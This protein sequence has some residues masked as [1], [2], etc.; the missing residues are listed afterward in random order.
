MRLKE[1]NNC[2]DSKYDLP[3]SKIVRGK[4]VFDAIFK[5]G[6]S[7]HGKVLSLRYIHSESTQPIYQM[8]FITKKKLGKAV[9][10]NLLRRK[11]RASFRLHQHLLEPIL[12]KNQTVQ[13]LCFIKTANATYQEIYDEMPHLL[14]QMQNKILIKV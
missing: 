14:K 7:I 8:G 11:M 9:L 12:Q 3:R 5:N 2:S 13:A 6:K 4:L 1:Q 10:R